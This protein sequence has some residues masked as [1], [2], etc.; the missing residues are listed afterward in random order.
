M[1]S[2]PATSR[3]PM[4]HLVRSCRRAIGAPLLLACCAICPALALAG[5]NGGQVVHGDIAITHPNAVTTDIHQ[6]TKKGIINWQDFSIDAPELVQF[7]QPDS[8]S[9]TLNPVVGGDPSHILGNLTANGQVFLVNK[10]GVY[11]GKGA[12]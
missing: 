7:R 6:G 3:F 1:T 8:S 5:P 10:H 2:S 9:V 4:Q 12:T 11:F